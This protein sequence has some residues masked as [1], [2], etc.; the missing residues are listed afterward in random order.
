MTTTSGCLVL[1]CFADQMQ[2]VVLIGLLYRLLSSHLGLQYQPTVDGRIRPPQAT[3]YLDLL[4]LVCFPYVDEVLG[5]DWFD[6]NSV[7][8]KMQESV[9]KGSNRLQ[10]PNLF[11]N[12]KGNISSSCLD[13]Y[14]WSGLSINRVHIR[15]AMQSC[16]IN[17]KHEDKYRHYGYIWRNMDK[18]G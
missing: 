6:L 17:G 11:H 9:A 15:K 10:K 12:L 2:S 1:T 13:F 14:V 7:G 5:Y 18:C 8:V 3:V 16:Q 4:Y